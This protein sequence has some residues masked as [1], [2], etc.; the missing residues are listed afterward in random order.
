M[1]SLHFRW[2]SDNPL[3]VPDVQ[4]SCNDLASVKGTKPVAAAVRTRGSIKNTDEFN[5]S[6]EK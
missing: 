1:K 4:M 6:M 2:K 5:P 3:R